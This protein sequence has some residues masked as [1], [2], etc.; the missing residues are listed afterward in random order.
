M[1]VRCQIATTAH[2][3]EIEQNIR[4]TRPQGGQESSA[5]ERAKTGYACKPHP[6]RGDYRVLPAHPDRTPWPHRANELT[7][8]ICIIVLLRNCAFKIF[9][10]CGFKDSLVCLVGFCS[11]HSQAAVGCAIKG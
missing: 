11:V 4:M 5:V 2:L 1:R 7:E 10:K 3:K 9:R 6:W 8:S